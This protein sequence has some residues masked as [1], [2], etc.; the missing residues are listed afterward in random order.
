MVTP[1][2]LLVVAY[3]GLRAQTFVA[4]LAKVEL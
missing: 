1:I 4:A 2:V 3:I